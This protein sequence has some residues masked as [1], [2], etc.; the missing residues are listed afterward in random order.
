VTTSLRAAF[1]LLLVLLPLTLAHAETRAAQ[2]DSIR[3]AAFRY[4][5][6][7]EAPRAGD[8]IRVYFLE[9]LKD[10]R[11]EQDPSGQMMKDLA[12]GP[13][14]IAKNSES[15]TLNDGSSGVTDEKTG[16]HGTILIVC[17]IRWISDTEVSVPVGF[18]TSSLGDEDYVYTLKKVGKNW[19]VVKAVMTGEA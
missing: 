7:K 17:D 1:A 5:L 10:Q 16:E 19:K 18:Y 15:R 3:E 9:I 6:P 11:I 4:M 8:R 12:G 13:V 2:E 14:R